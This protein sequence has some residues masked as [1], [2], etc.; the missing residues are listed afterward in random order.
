MKGVWEKV[1]KG[2][3]S[4]REG[5]TRWRALMGVTATQRRLKKVGRE[6][7]S[8]CL[9]CGEEDHLRH[10]WFECEYAQGYWSLMYFLGDEEFPNTFQP[11]NFSYSEILMGLPRLTLTSTQTE[12]ANLKLFASVAMQNLHSARQTHRKT[13]DKPLIDSNTLAERSLYTYRLRRELDDN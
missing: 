12:G 3:V 4:G 2:S 9:Q 7:E 1:W 13:P 6:K 11:A 10:Y 8:R 5:E